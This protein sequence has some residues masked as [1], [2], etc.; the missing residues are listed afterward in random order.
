MLG[1]RRMGWRKTNL[2]SEWRMRARRKTGWRNGNH[3]GSH[4]TMVI[5]RN[6]EFFPGL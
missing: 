1:G 5:A 2:M 4:K 3:V 6:K